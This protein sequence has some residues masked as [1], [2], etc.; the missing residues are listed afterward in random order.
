MERYAPMPRTWRA[1]MWLHAPWLLEILD[2]RGCGPD[3]D[4][5]LPE[6]GSPG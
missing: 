5:V 1:A 6:A 2:G 3:G 4:H